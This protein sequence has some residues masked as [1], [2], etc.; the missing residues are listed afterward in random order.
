M[1]VVNDNAPSE[2]GPNAAVLRASAFARRGALH[3]ERH[4]FVDFADM[5][6]RAFAA[7]AALDPRPDWVMWLDADEVHGERVRAIAR[8]ILPTLD[9]SV[10]SVDCYTYHFFGTFDWITDVARRFAFYRYDPS[11]RWVNPIHEKIVGLS[12]RAIVLPYIYYHYGNVAAAPLLADKY[13]RY[14]ALGNPVPPREDP[15]SI[16]IYL[17]KISAVR[18][19]RGEHPSA[20]RATLAAMRAELGPMFAAIDAAYRAGRTP[21][22]RAR[23]ALRGLNE[24]ARVGLR[25]LE[26]PA[27]SARLERR[28]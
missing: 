27:L 17:E 5:R 12:G 2:N 9:S 7:L 1:L 8:G 18:P 13:A 4:P 19:F 3:I 23:A 25:R 24:A 11:L 16:D 20:A 15:E 26:H 22:M 14:H 10:G 28:R 6:N 21:S